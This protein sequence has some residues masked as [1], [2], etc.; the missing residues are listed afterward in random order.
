MSILA[1]YT[2]IHQTKQRS[3]KPLLRATQIHS[4]F[5]WLCFLC[6]I[7]HDDRDL[8]RN[9]YLQ[10]TRQI[11]HAK[12]SRAGMLPTVLLLRKLTR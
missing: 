10:L 9:I 5:E 12:K 1:A 8:A 2:F 4:V 3:Q 7:F 11:I 6:C